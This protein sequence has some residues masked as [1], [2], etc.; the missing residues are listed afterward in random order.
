MTDRKQRIV[1]L[2]GLLV[3]AFLLLSVVITSAAPPWAPDTKGKPDHALS[4]YA[5]FGYNL[6][7]DFKI[8]PWLTR[9]LEGKDCARGLWTIC[10]S[11]S[12]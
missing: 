4:P 12:A 9:E 2:A 5:F 10:S 8:T 3:G 6:G 1:T 11:W 7:D